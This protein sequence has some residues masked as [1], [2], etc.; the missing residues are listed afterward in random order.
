MMGKYKII[1]IEFEAYAGYPLNLSIQ[2]IIFVLFRTFEI[3]QATI[4]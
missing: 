2:G 1:A 4:I 3:V